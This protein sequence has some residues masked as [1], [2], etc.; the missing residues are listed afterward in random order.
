MIARELLL[1]LQVVNGRAWLNFI[2]VCSCLAISAVYEL[3][4]WAVAWLTGA[5]GDYFLGTQ[6]YIWDTRSDMAWAMWGSIFALVGLSRIHGRQLRQF[7]RRAE[8]RSIRSIPAE[9][10]KDCVKVEI[11]TNTFMIAVPLIVEFS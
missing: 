8:L 2:I 3:I 1:R 5:A 6:G 7:C 11:G 10:S 4:E 9:L